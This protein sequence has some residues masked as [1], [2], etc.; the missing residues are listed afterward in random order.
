MRLESLPPPVLR[1]TVTE[2]NPVQFL[3]AY[4][5]AVPF[6]IIFY[7]QRAVSMWVFGQNFVSISCV[8]EG[9]ACSSF[10]SLFQ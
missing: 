8:N 4:F 2:F 10:P 5:L 6:N 3:T 9:I 1:C 7:Y